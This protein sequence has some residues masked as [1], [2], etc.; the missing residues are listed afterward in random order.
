MT[1][2]YLMNC[3]T[4]VAQL[5]CGQ[6]LYLYTLYLSALVRVPLVIIAQQL[7]SDWNR[8][9]VGTLQII[10]IPVFKHVLQ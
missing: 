8:I 2:I 10:N 3:F 7:E 6:C 5:V 1:S 9:V 4:F